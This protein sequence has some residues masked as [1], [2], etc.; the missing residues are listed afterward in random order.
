MPP[1]AAQHAVEMGGANA[2]APGELDADGA[3]E[4]DEIVELLHAWRVMSAIDQRRMRGLQSFGGGDIGENHEF[5][6]Q[7]MRLQPLRP[8]HARQA[9]LIVE[10][11]FA[12]RQIEI[13]RVASFAF[14]PDRGMRGPERLEDALQEG[15]SRL[16]RSAVDRGL[17]LFV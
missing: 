13:E 8:T 10:N 7:P 6:N 9:S 2:I 17:S 16:V 3:Q 11:E 12:L 14:D 15:R 4:L 5:L 1:H